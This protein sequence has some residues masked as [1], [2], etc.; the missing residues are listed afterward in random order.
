MNKVTVDAEA[1]PITRIDDTLDSLAGAKY[2]C[3]N[4]LTA[5]YWHVLMHPNSKYQTAF[6][7]R[8]GYITGIGSLLVSKKVLPN[9]LE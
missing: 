7:H 1:Y 3:T 9:S 5:G 6:V 4:D 8:N 2:F